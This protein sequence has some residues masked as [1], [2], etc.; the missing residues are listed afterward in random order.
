MTSK[1]QQHRLNVLG[2]RIKSG[3]YVS[4]FNFLLI[5]LVIA[6]V[7]VAAVVAVVVGSYQL[8]N[9]IL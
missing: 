5:W 6:L 2:Q 1:F 3:R 9:L 8:I 4:P 7:L